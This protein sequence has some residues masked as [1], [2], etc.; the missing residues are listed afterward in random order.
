MDPEPA[1]AGVGEY[2]D[3]RDLGGVVRCASGPVPESTRRCRSTATASTVEAD[4][5]VIVADLPVDRF[6]WSMFPDGDGRT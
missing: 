4:D 5:P 1:A 2:S 6:A 3:E